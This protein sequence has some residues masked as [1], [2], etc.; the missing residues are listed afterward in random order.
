MKYKHHSMLPIGSFARRGSI[1]GGRSIAVYG[2]SDEW[3]AQEETQEDPNQ[4]FITTNY[5]SGEGYYVPNPPPPPAPAPAPAPAPPPPPAAPAYVAPAAPAYVAP[6]APSRN[7]T[8]WQQVND[9]YVQ[10]L[11]RNADP[12]GHQNLYNEIASGRLSIEG[13]RNALRTSAEGV[14]RGAPSQAPAPAAPSA[15][16]YTPFNL[17]E[18]GGL[19][20]SEEQ[21]SYYNAAKLANWHMSRGDPNG[22]AQQFINQANELKAHL[23]QPYRIDTIAGDEYGTGGGAV[24]VT[25]SGTTP[26]VEN[27]QGEY[28][29][30]IA[31]SSSGDNEIASSTGAT[32]DT[33]ALQQQEADA[34][35][36]PFGTGEG[37]ALGYAYGIKNV[38]GD[39]YKKYDAQG[40]LTEFLNKDG[41][42]VKASD[43]KPIGTQFNAETGQ[44]DT[45]YEYGGRQDIVGNSYVPG[46]SPYKEDQ[47]GF[48]GEGG[49]GNIAGLV[50][51][52]LTANPA[53]FGAIGVPAT[54]GKAIV[55]GAASV[56]KG[57]N[58]GQSFEDALVNALKTGAITAVTAGALEK[59]GE[60][61][62]FDASKFGDYEFSDVN[63]AMADILGTST[64]ANAIYDA[65]VS[66]LENPQ[67][68]T[69]IP[70]SESASLTTV[71]ATPE[72]VAD[73]ASRGVNLP[74]VGDNWSKW[75]EFAE[76]PANMLI[77][78]VADQQIPFID[79]TAGQ[80]I[81]YE[82][83]VN[84]ISDAVDGFKA[85]NPSPDAVKEF[86]SQ[87][88]TILSTNAGVSSIAQ[89]IGSGLSPIAA[90]TNI[91]QPTGSTPP[92]PVSPEPSVPNL[93]STPSTDVENIITGG[94]APGVDADISDIIGGSGIGAG[95][96]VGTG[97]GTE[98]STGTGGGTG[99]GTGAGGGAGGGAGAGSGAGSG[100]GDGDYDF[101]LKRRKNGEEVT[102]LL[103]Q[104][105]TGQVKTPPV[106]EIDYMY[107]IGGDSV[108]A[109]PKQESLMPSPFEE[110]PEAVEGAM[111]RYQYYDPKGGYMYADGGMVAFEEGGDVTQEELEAA[112]RPVTYN[113]RI[114]ASGETSRRNK[115][116]ALARQ[117]QGPE[118]TVVDEYGNVI[119]FSDYGRAAPTLEDT[120]QQLTGM[121]PGV[122]RSAFLPYNKE[123]GFHVPEAIYGGIKSLIAPEQ[124]RKYGNVTDKDAIEMALNVMGGGLG[125]SAG[126]KNPT[127]S[128]GADL[129]MFVGPYSKTWDQKS[130]ER[131]LKLQEM[132]RTPEEIQAITGN[133]KSPSG[134]WSQM[135]S[136]K[137]A[138]T[139]PS[140]MPSG[141]EVGEGSV[142]VKDILKHHELLKAYPDIG[143]FP[144]VLT[145]GNGA[146]FDPVGG[147]IGLGD[148]SLS[149]Q[150]IKS[151]I[152]H[153]LQHYIQR[154]EG[155]PRGGNPEEFKA[156]MIDK[157]G[158]FRS[159]PL[160]KHAAELYDVFV[161]DPIAMGK[162]KRLEG[163]AQARATEKMME[164]NTTQQ[165]VKPI[166][167]QYDVP[168]SKL[169]A[170]YDGDY[171]EG[172]LIGDDD[173]QTI[174]DLY[175]MLRS[176]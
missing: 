165:R 68:L 92:V 36:R 93:P 3:W 5:E 171:A 163:E 117:Q 4:T 102:N 176:K 57:V 126:M 45:V 1:V 75:H 118:D 139:R 133:I 37:Q 144:V 6:A 52:A 33:K 81:S 113:P 61:G 145:P 158:L 100:T 31:G 16:T 152:L 119:R 132:G 77:P 154:Y 96:D 112:L 129:G 172:G 42:F 169:Q 30:S 148:K 174:D 80:G 11:G 106:A 20:G 127:G 15:S 170:R 164:S 128:G 74:K 8:I 7:E 14:A 143:E 2:D 95:T 157:N 107:D 124:A 44:L 10:E 26:V 141:Y 69:A 166:S 87:I 149:P 99:S 18:F 29:A 153:E 62:A 150:E 40:N 151:N 98:T 9:I 76:D 91:A 34:K 156:E 73:Y 173:L 84:Y 109:T 48:L 167:K 89:A 101:E 147:V 49:W 137:N 160:G 32:I 50:A 142:K 108:F 168:M 111:P 175:E 60:L 85:I 115:K 82:D 161:T 116:E 90:I 56:A 130:Y 51:V 13:A 138:L 55:A 123:A 103:S 38:N 162:Y 86:T 12:G 21:N 66:N 114:A 79:L 54:L 53:L 58:N 35:S 65:L 63:G 19:G 110:T 23:S 134:K 27:E 72:Q 120:V 43:V 28:L 131:A 78:D 94:Q 104:M 17:D 146:Y 125:V 39:V 159:N 88:D 25:P 70:G 122:D 97:T 135:I 136:D 59:L 121:E 83:F 105:A 64:D 41:Q 71:G 47:G 22:Y 46:M 24:L 155:W 67:A 140:Q